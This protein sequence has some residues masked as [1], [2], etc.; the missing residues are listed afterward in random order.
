MGAE[1]PESLNGKSPPATPETDSRLRMQRRKRRSLIS[2]HGSRAGG[3]RV[4]ALCRADARDSTQATVVPVPTDG[5]GWMSVFARISWT[6]CAGTLC[7]LAA[8]ASSC[9]LTSTRA[10]CQADQ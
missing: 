4:L 1:P 10:A 3:P 9:C 5:S 2:I 6:T 8:S 7:C